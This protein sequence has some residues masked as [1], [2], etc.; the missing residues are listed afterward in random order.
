MDSPLSQ[1][2]KNF[3]DTR[4]RTELVS[5]ADIKS[6]KTND[7]VADTSTVN[8]VLYIVITG[9]L[10]ASKSYSEDKDFHLYYIKQGEICTTTSFFNGSYSDKIKLTA[11]CPTE[12]LAIPSSSVSE[13]LKKYPVWVEYH[14]LQFQ[15]RLSYLLNDYQKNITENHEKR[16]LDFL[17]NKSNIINKKELK[18]THQ[19]IADELGTAREVVS[20]ILKKMEKDKVLTLHRSH[21]ML[22]DAI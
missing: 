3:K 5:V 10:K 9:C 12:V 21:I 17:K 6:F 4:L 16:V 15:T 18:V 13:W 22:H 2:L 14:L 7:I 8:N 1:L 19:V 20:R 11:E